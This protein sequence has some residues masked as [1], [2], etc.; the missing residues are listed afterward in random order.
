MTATD[1]IAGITGQIPTGR[2][3]AVMRIGRTSERV[4]H[5]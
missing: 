5:E 3:G 2:T 1:E 4:C